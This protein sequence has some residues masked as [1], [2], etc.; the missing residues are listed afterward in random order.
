MAA[1]SV[2]MVSTRWPAINGM[3]APSPAACAI[4]LHEPD[5]ERTS[6]VSILGKAEFLASWRRTGPLRFAG[7]SAARR[8]CTSRSNGRSATWRPAAA[9]GAG[10]SSATRSGCCRRSASSPSS[11]VNDAADAG[12]ASRPTFVAV[13]TG[14]QRWVAGAQPGG[15]G[16]RFAVAEFGIATPQGAANVRKLALLASPALCAAETGVEKIAEQQDEGG[17]G[18]EAEHARSRG[19][20]G[21]LRTGRT[22]GATS[23]PGSA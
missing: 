18:L 11:S 23:R 20:F 13:R 10:R 12:A 7:P 4:V 16:R 14:E 15:S 22:L 19:R 1:G 17:R 2:A 21:S 6:Q 3:D 8:R 9:T 5:E